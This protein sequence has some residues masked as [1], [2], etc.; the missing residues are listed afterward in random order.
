MEPVSNE[1]FYTVGVRE[2]DEMN[3]KL[4]VI[5]KDLK[6]DKQQMRIMK[7]INTQNDVTCVAL[8]KEKLFLGLVD[9]VVEVFRQLEL[10]LVN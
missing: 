5:E 10:E 2:Q 8:L 1:M 7:Q 6:T 3:V 4:W 9:G